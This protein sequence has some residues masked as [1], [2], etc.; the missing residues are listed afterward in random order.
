MN[1]EILRMQMLS[2]II[3]ESEYTAKAKLKENKEINSLQNISDELKSHNL[4]KNDKRDVDEIADLIKNNELQKAALLIQNLDTGIKELIL[5]DIQ[6]IDEELLNTMFDFPSD[7]LTTAKAKL[8]EN[9]IS[10]TKKLLNENFVGM[11]MVGNIFD[12][13]KTDYEIAFEHF[14]KGKMNEEMSGMNSG[15]ESYLLGLFDSIDLGDDFQEGP[16]TYTFEKINWADEDLYGEEAEMF[17]PAYDY[18][19]SKGNITLTD[20][21]SSTPVTFSTEGEDIVASFNTE[22]F[23]SL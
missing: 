14:S 18:I 4:R 20:P 7:Y 6:D 5:N 8:K 17:T 9:K 23:P 19:S 13:E 3:T 10:K 2:G 12:R 1:K 21:L 11:G 22:D 16:Q 15:V